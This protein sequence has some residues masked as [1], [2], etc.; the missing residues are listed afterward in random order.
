M[1]GFDKVKENLEGFLGSALYIDPNKDIRAPDT[2]RDLHYDILVLWNQLKSEP[3]N[4]GLMLPFLLRDPDPPQV[5]TILNDTVDVSP[6]DFMFVFSEELGTTKFYQLSGEDPEYGLE[7]VNREALYSSDYFSVDGQQ[8]RFE[9][10]E[11]TGK[12][13]VVVQDPAIEGVGISLEAGQLVSVYMEDTDETFEFQLNSDPNGGFSLEGITRASLKS[14]DSFLINQPNGEQEQHRFDIDG[15]SGAASLTHWRDMFPKQY[16]NDGDR[17]YVASVMVE[18]PAGDPF[19]Y[20][21]MHDQDGGY[22]AISKAEF[23][24]YARET[25]LGARI[26]WLSDKPISREDFD[27]LSELDVEIKSTPFAAPVE[28]DLPITSDPKAPA[29]TPDKPPEVQFEAPVAPV[30]PPVVDAPLSI[31]VPEEPVVGGGDPVGIIKSNGDFV[32]TTEGRLPPEMPSPEAKVEEPVEPKTDDSG[33]VQYLKDAFGIHLPN[34]DEVSAIQAQG[35]LGLSIPGVVMAIKDGRIEPERVEEV[36]DY[37]AQFDD[38]FDEALKNA[39]EQ[40]WISQDYTDGVGRFSDLLSDVA[41]GKE[42]DTAAFG[43]M[44]NANQSVASTLAARAAVQARIDAGEDVLT[45]KEEHKPEPTEKEAFDGV[46]FDKDAYEAALDTSETDGSAYIRDWL[47]EQHRVTFPEAGGEISLESEQAL[48]QAVDTLRYRI[49]D[50]VIDPRAMEAITA[51]LSRIEAGVS[52]THSYAQHIN[53]FHAIASEG[54]NALSDTMNDY[55]AIRSE[56]GGI[57]LEHEASQP[58][59]SI[60]PEF[61]PAYD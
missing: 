48:V 8:Y 3:G 45:R 12:V 10:D 15:G 55:M 31:V 35:M 37:V 54:G 20:M 41:D 23:D 1:A 16:A 29:D 57:I 44:R 17:V 36:I 43:L 58:K 61:E 27:R 42:F 2:P 30:A 22:V 11:D 18:N 6:G 4:E 28:P 9:R 21:L 46:E 47:R 60:A 26:Q 53:E 32:V 13:S 52:S 49:S 14:G 38:A 24:E 5:T 25:G 19:Q 59:P 51:E 7:E 56:R 50:G 33:V 39:V 40:E 34:V